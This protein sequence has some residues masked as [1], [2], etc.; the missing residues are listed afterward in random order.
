MLPLN[1]HAWEQNFWKK[2]FTIE[3]SMQRH[4]EKGHLGGMTPEELCL[5]KRLTS[6]IELIGKKPGKKL[7]LNSIN[8]F[9]KKISCI[10]NDHF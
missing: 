4:T 9:F 6:E 7:N 5:I 10:N 8:I 1:H 3:K 2:H